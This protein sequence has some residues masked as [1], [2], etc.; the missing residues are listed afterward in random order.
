M[1]VGNIKTDGNDRARRNVM[2]LFLSNFQFDDL[3]NGKRDADGEK[4]PAR[5]TLKPAARYRIT[6]GAA[7]REEVIE[8]ECIQTN[9]APIKDVLFQL[10]GNPLDAVFCFV[11]EKVKAEAVELWKEETEKDPRKYES[12]VELFWERLQA[13]N[14]DEAL[15]DR[16]KT[17]LTKER[18]H[19]VDFK[20]SAPN[21]SE[22]CI[23]ATLEMK[24]EIKKYMENETD[25]DGHK[26]S[27]QHCFL[28]ADIT[29]GMRT[30]N[31]AMSAAMQLL[32]YDGAHLERVVY[33]DFAPKRELNPVSNVQP[34]TDLYKLVAGVYAFTQYGRSEALN[35]YFA[36][37]TYEPLVELR[38]A[39][40][41]FSEAVQLCQ[42]NP[43]ENK[44]I[45]LIEAMERFSGEA[46]DHKSA[47][48]DLFK[49]M[50]PNLQDVYSA[51]ADKKSDGTWEINRLKVIEWSIDNKLLQQAV[52]FCT[53]W[54]PKYLLEHSVL[55][56]NDEEIQ[57]YC[58]GLQTFRPGEKNFFIDFCTNNQDWKQIQ[59][60]TAHDKIKALIDGKQ[61]LDA[62]KDALPK[63]FGPF[64]ED[65]A[66]FLQTADK[67]MARGNICDSRLKDIAE[68]IARNRK[69]TAAAVSVD[70]VKENLRTW[71]FDKGLAYFSV[72]EIENKYGGWTQVEIQKDNKKEKTEKIA[73]QMLK[74]GMMKTALR[75]PEK[76]VYFIKEYTYI[77]TE[78]RNK[79]CHATEE[80]SSR[81]DAGEEP[82]TIQGVTKRL[83]GYLDEIK[84]I[85]LLTDPG[86]P[87]YAGRWKRKGEKEAAR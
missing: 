58:N 31:M 85:D 23:R 56:T 68:R 46:E 82:L 33:S 75:D 45:A 40:D 24:S 14:E 18:F 39:M 29:G 71:V 79:I 69:K 65:L 63:N 38:K 7:G 84:R 76:A 13:I 50:M 22:E 41:A 64:L 2:I 80:E 19:L 86:K 44:L 36:G 30:A 5:K 35:E 43:I 78:L 51:M 20:E 16:L 53:E 26:L 66:R 12:H 17:P 72:P 74:R 70:E 87:K 55:F 6:R 42:T 49:E 3:N 28:Y 15:R 4:L 60:K 81:A 54:L 47:K 1:D 37:E 73:R 27:L 67:E 48:V 11:T 25:A 32:Q 52:T 21:P 8:P 34:I 83:T 10:N 77:R 57:Y 9:E 59:N 62:V 61:T